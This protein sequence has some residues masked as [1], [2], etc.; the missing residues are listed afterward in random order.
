MYKRKKQRELLE[1]G[2]GNLSPTNP[3]TLFQH[4]DELEEPT[5]AA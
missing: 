4:S 1:I 2:I 3:P 5:F